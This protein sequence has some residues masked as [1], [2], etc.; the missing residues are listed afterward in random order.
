MTILT[1]L[2]DDNGVKIYYSVMDYLIKGSSVSSFKINNQH[3]YLFHP[4][5]AVALQRL[6]A[7][8]EFYATNQT[9]Y[10][11]IPVVPKDITLIKIDTEPT[12]SPEDKE[13]FEQFVGTLES[14]L[15]KNSSKKKKPR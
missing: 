6:G 11:Q 4:Y 2:I 10:S 7:T 14:I 15:K 1:K 12:I 13:K 3:Y 9:L 5:Q 8:L